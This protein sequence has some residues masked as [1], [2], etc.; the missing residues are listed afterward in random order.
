VKQRD[1]EW[2]GG[3]GFQAAGGSKSA[4][5]LIGKKWLPSGVMQ[6]FLINTDALKEIPP[7]MRFHR[8][9]D[10]RIYEAPLVITTRGLGEEGFFAAIS[11]EDVVYTEEYYGISFPKEQEYVAHYLN[12]VLNSSLA[13]YF[14]FLTASVWGVERDKIEP[15]DLLR[16]PL[17]VPAKDNEQLI[18]LIVNMEKQLC[19]LQD[20]IARKEAKEQLDI[21]VFHLYDLSPAEQILV[22]DMKDYT[23]DLRMKREGSQALHRSGN[24]ELEAYT[25]SFV[26]TL[27]PYFKV[28]NEVKVVADVFETTAPLQVI[29]FSMIPVSEQT[30]SIRVI[31]GQ[32]LDDVLSKIALQLPTKVA[33]TVYTSRNLRLYVGN[34]F[35]IIKPSQSRYW[36]RSAALNDVDAVISELMKGTYASVR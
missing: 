13:R 20:K 9:R 11:S 16:F 22:Q 8:A 3:Q 7:E 2:L 24:K 23:I 32:V 14:L 5:E 30:S 19:F 12:G 27:Q 21:A 31:T 26:N 34:S 4:P 10:S 33:D 29:K 18:S 36:S 28:L 17:P 35:Y 15:N 25:S 1:T 6:P